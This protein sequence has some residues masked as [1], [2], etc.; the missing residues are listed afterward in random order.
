MAARSDPAASMTARMSS[1][2]TSAEAKSATRSESPVP[3]LSNR[4]SRENV[5]SLAKNSP[6]GPS[7]AY[8]SAVKT[9]PSTNTRSKGPSPTTE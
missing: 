1:M 3:R 2:R 5:A 4:I 8:S 7:H 9:E 6:G